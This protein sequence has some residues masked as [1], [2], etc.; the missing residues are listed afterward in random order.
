MPEFLSPRERGS[1]VFGRPVLDR[2]LLE[3]L[4]GKRIFPDVNVLLIALL[5]EESTSALLLAHCRQATLVLS[6]HV[7]DTARGVL[8]RG[9]PHLLGD[10]SDKLLRVLRA[11]RTELVPSPTPR[12]LPSLASELGE[13]DCQVLA[14]AL[15][16]GADMLFSLDGDFLES[17][18]RMELNLEIRPPGDLL[19]PRPLR[20]GDVL[21]LDRESW[22]YL[23][24]FIPQWGSDLFGRESPDR[25]FYIF[26]IADHLSCYYEAHPGRYVLEWETAAGAKGRLELPQ[27]VERRSQNYVFIS[28][29]PDHVM[30]FVN[31]ETRER[32]VRLGPIPRR[33]ALSP[34][35]DADGK[36]QI[37]GDVQFRALPRTL[38]ERRLRRH[39]RTGSLWL[40]DDEVALNDILGPL[41]EDG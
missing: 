17:G 5:A 24:W 7:R 29:A 27:E 40:T 18:L 10:Y 36:H 2:D 34:F 33:T 11:N 38:S 21:D 6:R 25:V 15:H 13:E 3:F 20:S 30:L 23:S 26:Q 4:E 37:D 12:G 9:A 19:W 28:A 16:T 41:L 8:N 1:S 14:D 32:D 35:N 22:T 31:G 39:W